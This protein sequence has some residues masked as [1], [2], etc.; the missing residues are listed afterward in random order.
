MACLLGRDAQCF[1]CYS[2]LMTSVVYCLATPDA[3]R[4]YVGVTSDVAHRLR[5]HRG[6][7]QGGAGATSRDGERIDWRL[8]CVLRGFP[9]AS[10][11]PAIRVA[12]AS[13][14]I[15]APPQI[16]HDACAPAAAPPAPGAHADVGPGDDDGARQERLCAAGGVAKSGLSH[17]VLDSAVYVTVSVP[18]KVRWSDSQL[19]R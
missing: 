15:E 14:R 5:Q 3:Q 4:S 11:R 13:R 6:E 2:V 9:H 16:S 10:P 8:V 1:N 12:R 17:V 18:S 7:I 19:V